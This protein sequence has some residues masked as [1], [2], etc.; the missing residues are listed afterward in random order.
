MS[1]RFRLDTLI[2]GVP[3]LVA[4]LGTIMRYAYGAFGAYA[5]GMIFGGLL[6]ATAFGGAAGRFLAVTMDAPKEVHADAA[7]LG[8]MLV[9]ML[10]FAATVAGLLL[11]SSTSYAT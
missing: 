2:L 6:L 1:V 8:M 10:A 3:L 7:Y 11:A 9:F 5:A 4:A